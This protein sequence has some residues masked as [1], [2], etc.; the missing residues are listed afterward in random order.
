[1]SGFTR[2]FRR[3]SKENPAPAGSQENQGQQSTPQSQTPPSGQNAEASQPQAP[4]QPTAEELAAQKAANSAAKTELAKARFQKEMQNQDLMYLVKKIANIDLSMDT[5]PPVQ[6]DENGN[7]IEPPKNITA[8]S[9]EEFYDEHVEVW[10][11][12]AGQINDLIFNSFEQA[13]LDAAGISVGE[14]VTGGI[15]GMFGVLV[16][17]FKAWNTFAKMHKDDKDRAERGEQKSAATRWQHARDGMEAIVDVINNTLG[18]VGTFL[19]DGPAAILGIIS[20]CASIFM[21]FIK[22]ADSGARIHGINKRKSKLWAKIEQKRMKYANEPGAEVE[23]EAYT[24]PTGFFKG[25]RAHR[26]KNKRDALRAKLASPEFAVGQTETLEGKHRKVKTN[27]GDS[28]TGLTNKIDAAKAA[29]KGAAAGAPGTPAPTGAPATQ[30]EA[31][32][33]KEKTRIR[34]MEA[35]HTIEEYYQEDQAQDRQIKILGH[36]LEDSITESVDIVGNLADLSVVGASVG[37]ILNVAASCY[38]LARHAGSWA[39]GKVSKL[40][41]HAADKD[42][43]RSEMARNMFD[44]IRGMTEG[45]ATTPGPYGWDGT[46]FLLDGVPDFRIRSGADRLSHMRGMMTGLDVRIDPLLKA[47]NKGEFVE[48]LASAFSQDGNG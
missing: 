25:T 48:S 32:K 24:L 9:V 39:Y 29:R 1:M 8:E 38:G 34:L 5:E 47:E 42:F 11:E 7:P 26:I 16:S 10:T 15:F 3:K 22:I 19:N 18:L 20:N 2:L 13:D 21:S 23:A 37:K 46:T 17:A 30:T 33:K 14:K 36:S 43:R 40:T 45:N 35:L 4:A 44:S 41:G 12:G 6:Q 27:Y 28:Y 31:E